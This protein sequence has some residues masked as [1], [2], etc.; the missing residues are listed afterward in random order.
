[1][2]W[3]IAV[4]TIVC[5]PLF[6]YLGVVRTTK[7]QMNNK[8]LELADKD[9]KELRG[10]VEE[11]VSHLEEVKDE[12]TRLSYTVEELKKDV[13]RHNNVI[14]RT[15]ELERKVAVL[16]NREAVSEHRLTDLEKAQ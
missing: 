4:L 3:I 5:T 10:I 16:E 6:T 13:M 9:K 11:V 1:M 14:E 2:E 15:Y 8:K 12:Q 7:A